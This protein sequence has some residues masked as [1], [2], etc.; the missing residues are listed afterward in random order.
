MPGKGSKLSS[1]M[2]PLFWRMVHLSVHRYGSHPTG[3][4]LV[5]LTI[6]LLDEVGAN[7]TVS[8]LADIVGLPKSSVSR[9]VSSEMSSGF[10]TEIIDPGDRRRRMLILTEQ[11]RQERVWHGQQ[12]E[13][14]EGVARKIIA[15]LGD[16]KDPAADMQ[17]A[18][19]SLTEASLS[20][21][22]D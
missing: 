14:I 5:V 22:P 18:M 7:P 19:K 9:Y 21:K 17:A 2:L 3:E 15:G 12:L 13:N 10:L 4:L 16:S 1:E 11:A 20:K 8:E 6:M